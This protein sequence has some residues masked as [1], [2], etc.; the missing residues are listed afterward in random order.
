MKRIKA[1]KVSALFTN[2][3]AIGKS[4][5]KVKKVFYKIFL[6]LSTRYMQYGSREASYPLK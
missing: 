4:N 6:D 3:N 2:V 1:K 5:E